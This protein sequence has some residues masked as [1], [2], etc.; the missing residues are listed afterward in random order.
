MDLIAKL[1]SFLCEHIKRY[2]GA[3]SGVTSYLSKHTCEEFIQL[4]AKKVAAYI[5][6]E[7]KLAMYFSISVDSTPDVAHVDQLT[8]IGRYVLPNGKSV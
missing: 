3:G 1:D 4:M 2:G 5:T 6:A 7:V 8:F